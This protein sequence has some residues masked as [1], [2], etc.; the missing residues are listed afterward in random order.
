MLPNYIGYTVSKVR[1]TVNDELKRSGHDLSQ[2]D[3]EN[4]KI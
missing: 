1:V 4:C 2:E 3:G